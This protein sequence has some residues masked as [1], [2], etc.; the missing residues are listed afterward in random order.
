MNDMPEEYTDIGYWHVTATCC[1]CG[2]Q[3]DAIREDCWK[4]YGQFIT[5]CGCSELPNP[6][7]DASL[8][9]FMYSNIY[10]A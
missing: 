5:D 9:S 8:V 3:V 2:Q 4:D 7:E 1:H 10:T 6:T